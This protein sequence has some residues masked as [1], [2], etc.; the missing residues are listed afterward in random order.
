MRIAVSAIALALL[1]CLSPTTGATPPPWSA[2]AQLP[3]QA[4]DRA[5]PPSKALEVVVPPIAPPAIVPAIVALFSSGQT[6]STASQT[7]AEAAI[8]S[9][10]TTIR[11]KLSSASVISVITMTGQRGRLQKTKL[12]PLGRGGDL[13][14]SRWRFF[15]RYGRKIGEGNLLCRWATE[16]RRL[17]WGEARLPRGRLVL[18][19][20]SQTRVLGEYAVIG[21]TGVYLFKQGLLSF[22]QLS[23]SKYAIKVLLA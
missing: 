4:S 20:S 11:T 1:V 2:K 6:S 23:T 5:H 8:A 3:E 13:E 16:F 14:S 15:D 21:G 17:C 7:Q 10:T 9:A 18:L 22:R 19:G 12:R